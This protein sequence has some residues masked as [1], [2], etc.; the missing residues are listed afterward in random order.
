MLRTRIYP[1]TGFHVDV[2]ESVEEVTELMAQMSEML[3]KSEQNGTTVI[4]LKD[5]SKIEVKE[6][7]AVVNAKYNQADNLDTEELMNWMR[8]D[9]TWPFPDPHNR[10]KVTEKGTG[11]EIS[12]PAKQIQQIFVEG[13]EDE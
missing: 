2:Q 3:M 6:N 7:V 13:D 10:F 1:V 9:N 4:L 12:L 8:W 5:G 11:K